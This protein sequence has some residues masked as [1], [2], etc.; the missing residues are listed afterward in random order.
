[1]PERPSGVVTFLFTDIEGSTRMLHALGPERY[2]DALDVHRQLLRTAFARNDGHEEGTEG[3]SFMVAFARPGDALAAAVAAQEALAAHDWPDAERV[4]VRAGIHTGEATVSSSG[5]IGVAVHRAA[6]IAAAGHGGQTLVSHTTFDLVRDQALPYRLVDLGQ[7]RLKDLVEPQHLYQLESLR[8]GPVR[9]FPALRTAAERPTNLP[10]QSSALIG[11]ERD[12]DSLANLVRDPGVRLVTLT[13]VGGAGKTRLALELGSRM[14]D[15]FA[16]GVWFV[17]LGAVTDPDLLASAIGAALSVNEAAGQ[18]LAAFLSGKH[19]MLIIDNFEQL[20]AASQAITDLTSGAPDIRIVMT[21]REAL[22]LSGEHVF[23]VPALNQ[24]DC[25]ELFIRRATAVRSTFTPS[26]AD[27][28]AIETICVRL[29]GL[30]LAIELAA[31]RVSLLSPDQILQRLSERLKLLTGGARDLPLRHQTLRAALEWSHALL[32]PTEQILFARIAVFAGGFTLDAAEAICDADLDVLASLVDKSLIKVGGERFELLE[33]VREYALERLAARDDGEAVRAAHAAYYEELV[34]RSYPRR[35]AA[36][37]EVSSWLESEIGNLRAALDY[38]EGVD[39]DRALAMAA[40]LGWFWHVHSHLTEGRARLEG[41]LQRS[42]VDGVARARALAA[43][44]EVAIWQGDFA[45]AGAALNSATATF[46]EHGLEQERAF[47]L[48]ELGWGQFTA[49]LDEDARRTMDESLRIQRAIGDELLINRAQ[50]GLLQMLVALGEVD[51]VEKLAPES[52]EAA[53][54]LG[55]LRGEHFAFHFLAD[56]ALIHG[57]A[58]SARV[59]YRD[60]L[61]AAIPLGDRI[62]IVFEVQGIAMSLA[63]S[64]SP[65]TA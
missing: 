56:S 6:R 58:E 43:V 31:A 38:I 52:L 65:E 29:D 48:Y 5:Y 14:L 37:W 4:N 16:D 39:V 20:V 53:R 49:G 57:D 26:P 17:P 47:A 15:D 12:L 34:E 41:L 13:G 32:T 54:R 42:T 8:D 62:E 25:V 19:L 55:D 44:G 10:A 7:H 60:A 11:R 63:G 45:T 21:S 3:D 40:K 61:R 30:P 36:E 35:I 24:I 46:K 64:G 9:Q 50:L 18:S 27:I 2:G 51:Q 59:R 33:T 1:M 23:A 22:R 28:A